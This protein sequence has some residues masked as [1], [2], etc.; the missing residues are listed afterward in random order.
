VGVTKELVRA[1]GNPW[2]FAELPDL[3]ERVLP[4]VVTVDVRFDAGAG[5]GSGFAVPVGSDADQGIVVTNAHVVLNA[6]EIA[7]VFTDNETV[8]TQ[9]RLLEPGFDLAILALE[10]PPPAT[11]EPRR[12]AEIR[13]GEAVIAIGAPYALSGSVSLGIVSALNRA[14]PTPDEGLLD[15]IQTDAAINDGNSG[16]P[17]IGLDGRVLGINSQGLVGQRGEVL[18][19]IKFAVPV[20]FAISAYTEICETGAK[21]LRRGRIGVRTR[22]HAL[23]HALRARLKQATGALIIDD[24]ERDTPAAKAGLKRGDVILAFDGAVVDDPGDLHRLLDRTRINRECHV[25]YLRKDSKRQSAIVPVE[26]KL[27]REE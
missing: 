6:C 7:I 19:G 26:R 10:R 8:E 12:L 1:G 18:P 27:T 2:S 22:T 23:S 14:R 11:L 21:H 20:E 4:A 16:G 3:V 5:N 25:T 13:V 17:L 9:V 15:M 24:P